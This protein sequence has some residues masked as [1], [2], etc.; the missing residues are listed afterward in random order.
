VLLDPY[1]TGRF[2]V[3]PSVGAADG[4]PRTANAS[5]GRDPQF[6]A[7]VIGNSTGQ[8]LDPREL[9]RLTGL[10][11]VQMTVPGTRIREQLAMA[12]WFR[13]HHRQIGALVFVTDDSA[14]RRDAIVPTNPFPFWLYTDSDLEYLANLLDARA[15]DIAWRQLQ[16]RLGRRSPA[17]PIGYWNYEVDAPSDRHPQPGEQSTL[18]DL[19]DPGDAAFPAADRL[20]AVLQ[21]LSADVPVVA[22]MPP[23]FYTEVPP[24]GTSA[25]LRIRACKQ[26]FASV[27]AGRARSGFLDFRIDNPATRDPRNFVDTRHYRA[28]IARRIERAIAAMIKDGRAE[29]DF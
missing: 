19:A 7:A 26:A 12:R 17:D 21:A 10:S 8:A 22:V 15:I 25:A 13:Q 3:L 18:N 4:N 2:A 16:V 6:N 11:F 20:R 28:P 27:V 23:R 29:V 1:D 5:R 24:D 9:S 14:C